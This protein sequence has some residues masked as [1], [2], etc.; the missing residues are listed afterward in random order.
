MAP[1]PSRGA[2]SASDWSIEDAFEHTKTIILD[3]GQWSK[4]VAL[5]LWTKTSRRMR[6]AG[7][8]V[9]FA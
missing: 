7:S 6:A 4:S 9:L 1:A 3:G 5:L 8:L 2:F